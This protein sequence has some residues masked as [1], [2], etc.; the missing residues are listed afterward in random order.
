MQCA[1]ALHKNLDDLPCL[2]RERLS[3]SNK[4]INKISRKS[5]GYMQTSTRSSKYLGSGLPVLLVHHRE[6]S[7]AATA[8]ATPKRLRNAKE[9]SRLSHTWCSLTLAS[10][11]PSA[12][13]PR[14]PPQKNSA[15]ASTP[16][17]ALVLCGFVL[18]SELIGPPR[19]KVSMVEQTN[20]R[21]MV[22]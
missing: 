11:Q 2:A 12:S 16:S 3:A 15:F 13:H 8:A 20:A 22:T 14:T 6:L 5:G 17:L 9:A 19:T 1:R 4:V 18:S 21:K 10:S 7:V